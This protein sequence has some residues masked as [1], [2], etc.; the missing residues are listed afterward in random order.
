MALSKAEFE[1][2]PAVSKKNAVGIGPLT[3]IITIGEI[4]RSNLPNPCST[5][6][7]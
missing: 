1:V 6:P 5:R 4:F 3:L 2:V 7:G